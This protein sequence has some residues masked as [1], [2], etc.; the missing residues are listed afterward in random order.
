MVKSVLRLMLFL[1]WIQ[2]DA[3]GQDSRWQ[4]TIDAEN[5]QSFYARIGEGKFV[6][7]STGHLA[8]SQLKDGSYDLFIG[9]PDDKTATEQK[10]TILVDGKD[11]AYRLRSTGGKGWALFNTLTPDIK[12]GIAQTGAEASATLGKAVKKDD[13]F[14]QLM[15]AVVNDTAVLYNSYEAE[16]LLKDTVRKH[17]AS[18]PAAKV[19]SPVVAIEKKDS[20]V[21]V[22]PVA[23]V[24][25]EKGPAVKTAA[26]THVSIKKLS[27]RS[28]TSSLQLKYLDLSVKGHT[29][30][31][32][33]LIPYAKA[34]AASTGLQPQ[35]PAG[36]KKTA[37]S[38]AGAA[39]LM[40]DSTTPAKNTTIEFSDCK[41]LATD[42]DVDVLRVNILTANTETDKMGAARK[43]FKTM[44]FSVKQVRALGELFA[45]DQGRYRFYE[46]AYPYTSDRDHFPQLQETL[47]DEKYVNQ[48]KALA[49]Q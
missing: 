14:S 12:Q 35:K 25:K 21:A 23:A 18:L 22:A 37:A 2:V 15:A 30:T 17:V 40:T 31:I 26:V 5:G 1:V 3:F 4:L 48:L 24:K 9:F 11:Q 34:A 33:I 32:T 10:F 49:N 27:Q 43:A 7:S 20:G 46:T 19:D 13:A 47:T 41:T 38:S 36:N 44:C 42:Y 16:E 28:L 45:S 6:S 39:K 29:D 8:I